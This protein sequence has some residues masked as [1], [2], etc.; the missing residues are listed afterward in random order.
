MTAKTETSSLNV[1][2]LTPR[3]ALTPH[4][5]ARELHFATH[6]LNHIGLF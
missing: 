3:N 2:G 4:L 6:E 1:L 5:K